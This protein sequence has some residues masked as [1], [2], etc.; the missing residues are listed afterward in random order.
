MPSRQ[1]RPSL[2][3]NGHADPI[4]RCPLLGERGKHLLALSFAG[5]DPTRTIVRLDLSRKLLRVGLDIGGRNTGRG[6]HG[7]AC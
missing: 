5:L 7:S 1:E 6:V 3:P 4:E 2:A